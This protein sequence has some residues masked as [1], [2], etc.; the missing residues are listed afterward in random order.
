MR[1]LK[2]LVLA[3]T[4]ML[5]A[6]AFAQGLGVGKQDSVFLAQAGTSGNSMSRKP[7][8]DRET[9]TVIAVIPI[10]DDGKFATSGA[11]AAGREKGSERAAERKSNRRAA[12]QG[13][14]QARRDDKESNSASV[15]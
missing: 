3:L 9:G 4:P 15:N 12:A 1:S 2:Y 10:F 11:N 7:S 6:G 5:G 13:K 14:T 8:A